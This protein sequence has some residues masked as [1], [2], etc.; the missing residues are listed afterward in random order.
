MDGVTNFGAAAGFGIASLLFSIGLVLLSGFIPVSGDRQGGAGRL[1]LVLVG[2]M[3]SLAL[4]G[5]AV[6]I[7]LLSLSA[8]WAI[9]IGGGC[10]LLAPLLLEP[11]PTR[12]RDELPGIVLYII[13]AAPLSLLAALISG[14]LEV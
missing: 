13:I 1:I 7:A 3:L 14:L 4:A 5:M 2:G 10:F 12:L 9:V 11:L 6:Q 8:S